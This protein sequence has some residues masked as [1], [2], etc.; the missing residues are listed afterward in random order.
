MFALIKAKQYELRNEGFKEDIMIFQEELK[1]KINDFLQRVDTYKEEYK[2]SLQSR[3]ERPKPSGSNV[4]SSEDVSGH[5]NMSG[6]FKV[7]L[8]N[9]YANNKSHSL[10][11]PNPDLYSKS[12]ESISE[13][14]YASEI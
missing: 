7:K 12:H 13:I 2:K 11:M 1:N 9:P 6:K 14:N 3:N 5:N 10:T 4:N 8:T